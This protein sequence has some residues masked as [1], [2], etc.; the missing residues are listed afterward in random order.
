MARAAT[1]P[2][3][4]VRVVHASPDVGIVDV[5]VDGKELL[6]SFQFATV[7]EYLPLPAGTHSV[8]LALLGKGVG[9]SIVTENIEVKDGAAYT[10]VGL[11][12]KSSGFSFTVFQ[13]DNTAPKTGS[14]V[15][16]YHLAPGTGSAQVKVSRSSTTI[17]GLN[18][19]QASNYITVGAGERTFTLYAGPK[20]VEL[21]L[22][23]T[24]KDWNVAS[25]FAIGE[26]EGTPKLQLISAQVMGIPGL[27]GTGSDPSALVSAPSFPSWQWLSLSLLVAC[28]LIYF[29]GRLVRHRSQSF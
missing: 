9:A 13:D 26:Q 27:P 3:A 7:T 28:V 15:R 11:G 1:Q 18:Y 10:I 4:M 16:A 21:P 23:I 24:L 25:I 8:E 22:T 20:N 19:K 2:T 14:K 6:R 12:T 29:L 5:F 17:S